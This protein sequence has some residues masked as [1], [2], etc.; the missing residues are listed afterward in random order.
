MPP[1]RRGMSPDSLVSSRATSSGVAPAFIR[2]TAAHVPSTSAVTLAA[3]KSIGSQSSVASVGK[4]NR[5]PITP[6]IVRGW[7]N[8]G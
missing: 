7:P 5:G 8:I 6:M 1:K 3:R 2:A 4:R